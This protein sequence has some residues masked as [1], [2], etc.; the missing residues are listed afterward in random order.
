MRE[1][2]ITALTEKGKEAIKGHLEES[3]KLKWHERMMFKNL[4]YVQ[5]VISKEPFIF[6]LELRKKIY[7]QLVRGSDMATQLANTLHEN[8]ATKDIDY[9]MEVVD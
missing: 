9:T 7:Q 5:E 2:K 8:G 1:I 6:V 3:A 4:G